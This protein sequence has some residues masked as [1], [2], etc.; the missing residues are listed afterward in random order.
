MFIYLS[1]ND[2][3]INKRRLQVENR[4]NILLVCITSSDSFGVKSSLRSIGESYPELSIAVV[5]I[6]NNLQLTQKFISADIIVQ[7]FPI[8]MLF[9]LGVFNRIIQTDLSKES[10]R[11]AL[12]FELD[13]LDVRCTSN[14]RSEYL[15]LSDM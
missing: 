4:D 13:S 9:K 7:D 12:Y 15:T 8:F 3:S 1:H 11:K 2:F 14:I 6:D 5:N 10:V